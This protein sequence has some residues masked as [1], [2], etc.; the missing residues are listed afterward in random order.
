MSWLTRSNRMK[1]LVFAI[2]CGFLLT[3]LFALGLGAGMEFKDA[4][5]D[6][7]NSGKSILDWSWGHW[8]WLDL[9]ATCIGGLI[10]QAFQ[11]LVIYLIYTNP[12]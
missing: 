3:F 10:G 9:T 4:A 5:Y 7:A 1:H 6:K 12:F 11:A 8:D 2:P